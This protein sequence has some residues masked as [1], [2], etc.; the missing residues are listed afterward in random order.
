MGDIKDSDLTGLIKAKSSAPL[1]DA[2]ELYARAILMRLGFEVGKVDLSAGPFDLFLVV[3][4][5]PKGDKKLLRVQIKTISSSLQ[6]QAGSR[7]G[8]DRT[9]NS[10][11]KVYK[12]DETHNDLILGV[13][14]HTLDIYIFPTRFAKKYGKSIGKGK[15]S[16]LK[17][18]WDILKNWNP[19]YLSNLENK[20]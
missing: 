19:K 6:L 12:Y 18:N 15:I 20:L 8:I 4:T 1:G 2:H 17:N 13:D 3:Y 10:D 14:T 7:G 9:Y 11:V 5:A 16:I